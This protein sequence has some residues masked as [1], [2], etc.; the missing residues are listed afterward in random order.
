MIAPE[1]LK[2]LKKAYEKAVKEKAY[3]FIFN[4]QEVLTDY[5]KYLIQYLES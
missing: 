5:A 3:S 2:E 1:Y 4:E